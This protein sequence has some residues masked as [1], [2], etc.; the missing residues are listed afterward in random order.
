LPIG[1]RRAGSRR[2]RSCASPLRQNRS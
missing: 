2:Q 1:D